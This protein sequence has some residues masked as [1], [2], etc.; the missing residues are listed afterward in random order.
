M[1]LNELASKYISSTEHVFKHM[2]VAETPIT[3]DF[4]QVS[5]V[6]DFAKAYLEDARHYREKKKFK[7]SLTSIAYCEG[8]LDALRLLGAVRFEW[9]T[10]KTE[11]K[12]SGR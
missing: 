9:P 3:L 4:P 12:P 1:S 6:V 11:R 5:N 10:I 8:L 7:V 2:E